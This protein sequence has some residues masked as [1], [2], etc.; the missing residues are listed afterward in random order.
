MREE[1]RHLLSIVPNPF[2]KDIVHSAWDSVPV[3]VETINRTAFEAC[4]ETIQR[5]R[6]GGESRGLVLHGEPGSGKTHLLQR[7]RH[8]TQQDADSWFSYVPPFTTPD[9]FFRHLLD[10]LVRDL[11]RSLPGREELSQ[12]E[13]V[14]GRQLLQRPTAP[15]HEVAAWWQQ[16]QAEHPPGPALFASLQAPFEDLVFRLRLDPEVSTVLRHYL[17]R[18]Q[19]LE[20]YQ[21]LLGRALPEE[22]VGRIG[23]AGTLDDEDR[24]KQA[25]VTFSRLAGHPFAIILAFDQIEG[26]QIDPSDRYGLR[27]FAG[28]VASHLFVE[29]RNLAAISCVQ[30]SFLQVLREA[31]REAEYDRLAQDQ[32][33]LTLLSR[34]DAL[35]LV[36]RR[37]EV[38]ED[39]QQIRRMFGKQDPLWPL[40]RDRIEALV[41]PEGLSARKLLRACRGL[42][43]ETRRELTQSPPPPPPPPDDDDIKKVWEQVF[44]EEQKRPRS[45]LDEGVY[46]GGLLL[47]L[48]VL[49][50]AGIQGE[51]SPIRDVDLL[52]ERG[53]ERIGVAVCHAD[54][55]TSLAARLRRLCEVSERGQVT[56][57]RLIRDGRLRD[58][59]PTARATRQYLERLLA[60]GHRLLRPPA[61]AYAA[62]A[63]ALRLMNEAKAGD[64]TVNGRDVSPEELKT[65]LAQH[66][67]V[68][69][70]DFFDEVLRGPV[71]PPEEALERLRE[72]LEGRWLLPAADVAHEL[73]LPEEKV[74][75]LAAQH[76]PMIGY[77]PGPPAVVF[78]HP[79]AVERP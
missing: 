1:L 37:L 72:C 46:A 21:W 65:W 40:E 52:L 34:E 13:L 76:T 17:A 15:P 78:L 6:E 29:C 44:A 68:P 3:D 59:P 60:A 12:I 16:I 31:V 24:A 19:R 38:S 7:L 58:I 10:R 56:R 49:K 48:E 70:Q 69:L 32:A 36:V 66:R 47:L 4:L 11:L 62:L 9:R 8:R 57:L 54:H 51:R 61:E 53:A 73:G 33:A 22:A 43:E 30:T 50:P 75:V 27:A 63:A 55:M 26:L 77:L 2:E 14:V 39:L 28:G 79:E 71:E 5:V 41:P 64:L 67:P 18:C 35:K 23:A 74:A 25:I 45:K 42:F 20:A